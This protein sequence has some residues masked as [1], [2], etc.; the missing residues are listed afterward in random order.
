[1]VAGIAK[2]RLEEARKEREAMVASRIFDEMEREVSA[3]LELENDRP[4][5]ALLGETD[6]ETWAPFVVGY[7]SGARSDSPKYARIVAAEGNTSENKRRLNWALEK[8]KNEFHSSGG[9]IEAPPS[10]AP[11]EPSLTPSAVPQLLKAPPQ[12]ELQTQRGAVLTEER[13]PAPPATKPSSDREIIESLN[14]APERRKSK[15]S[16]PAES[17]ADDPFGDYLRSY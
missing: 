1:V 6:P 12:N 14:R 4:P 9:Q 11:R 13:A 3:F 15:S 8:A 7:F 17:K 5:Y 10:L 16:A 2:Q